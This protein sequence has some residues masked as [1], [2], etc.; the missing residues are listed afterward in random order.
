MYHTFYLYHFAHTALL[1]KTSFTF[2]SACKMSYNLIQIH[3]VF[4]V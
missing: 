3:P 2:L 1:H 4:A